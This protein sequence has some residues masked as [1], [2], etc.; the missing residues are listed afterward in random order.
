MRIHKKIMAR[1]HMKRSRDIAHAVKELEAKG[2]FVFRDFFN[3]KEVDKAREEISHWL[4]ADLEDRAKNG[5]I[6]AWHQSAIGTTILT[7][8][9]HLMLDAYAKSSTLDRLVETILT[10]PYSS[11]VLKELAGPHIKLRGYNVQKLTGKSDPKPSFGVASNPHEWHRDSPGEIG[12]A[13]FLEDV[14]GP[15]NGATS[16]VT[17]SHYFPY[18]PRWNCLFGQP[19]LLR[20]GG[21]GVNLFL[22]FNIFNRLLVKRIVNKQATG[23]YGRQGDFYFFINDL[24]HGR[25]PNTQG[26]AGIKVMIG[27]FAVDDPFPDSVPVPDKDIVDKLPPKLGQ[28][29]AQYSPEH[30]VDNKD[31]IIKRLRWQRESMPTPL[32]FGLAKAERVAADGLS[33]LIRVIIR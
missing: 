11:E 16:I 12:I 6:D 28:V 31:S 26:R 10:D 7:P 1:E 27:A 8:P 32:I 21:R 3:L 17:G 23:A 18:C 5:V 29:A 25:E 15:N 22:R 14:P 20:S 2:F 30:G 33:K 24:W 9:T 19:Y 4:D 13:I